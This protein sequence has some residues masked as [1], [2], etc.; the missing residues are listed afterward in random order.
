[1][2]LRVFK[3]VTFPCLTHLGALVNKCGCS[4]PVC[5]CLSF[6]VLLENTEKKILSAR[7]L[8]FVSPINRNTTISKT[9]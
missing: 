4:G 7:V 5:V 1:M 9:N 3:V 8:V 2:C 6:A